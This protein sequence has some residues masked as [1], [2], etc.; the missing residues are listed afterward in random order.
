MKTLVTEKTIA[1]FKQNGEKI[2]IIN[3]DTLITN[4]AK[5]AARCANISFVKEE[6]LC[7]EPC[8][9][10]KPGEKT[11]GCPMSYDRQVI[12]EAVIKALDKKGILDKILD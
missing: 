2:V 5:D 4:A 12:V 8:T 10:G 1:E 9:Q 11:E 6:N 7:K 3:D